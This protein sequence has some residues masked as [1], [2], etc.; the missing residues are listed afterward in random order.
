MHYTIHLSEK[1]LVIV[2][3]V[4]VHAEKGIV[5]IKTDVVEFSLVETF[6]LAG[7]NANTVLQ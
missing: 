1:F 2:H 3:A 5:K 6:T 4:I 7:I